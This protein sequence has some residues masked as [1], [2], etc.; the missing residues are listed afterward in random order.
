MITI[1]DIPDDGLYRDMP[2]R[3]YYRLPRV[4]K[5]ALDKLALGCFEI[6][7]NR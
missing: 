2:G 5:S 1:R 3:D 7:R 4:S 6:T